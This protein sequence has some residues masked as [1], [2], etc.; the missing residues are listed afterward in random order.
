MRS[1]SQIP[2]SMPSNVGTR[3][4]DGALIVQGSGPSH[5]ADEKRKTGRLDK[6]ILVQSQGL[7]KDNHRH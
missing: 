1:R 3:A 4:V 5:G 2:A 6:T 7:E